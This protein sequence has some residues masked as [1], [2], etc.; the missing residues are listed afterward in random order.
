MKKF[1][2]FFLGSLIG[3][4]AGTAAAIFFAPQSGEKTRENIQKTVWSIRS[5]YDKAAA[6]KRKELED[7][8]D[9]RRSS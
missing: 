8:L 1:F 9:R 6:E 4:A 7:D 2:K 3:A 5:E